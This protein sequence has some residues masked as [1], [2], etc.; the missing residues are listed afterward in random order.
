MAPAS[1]PRAP[2]PPLP[3]TFGRRATL[4]DLGLLTVFWLLYFWPILV[5]RSALI[6]YDLL[7]QHY[8][9]QAFVHRALASGQTPLWTPNILSGYPIAADPLTQLFYPPNLLMHLLSPGAFLPY[10]ALE[11]QA[12][13]HFLFAAFGTYFLARALAGSRTG[14]LLAALVFAFGSFFAW[15]LPHLSPISTLSWLPWILLAYRRA[16]LER[17]PR[18][19]AAAGFL[20]GLMALAG[21]A[22]TIVQI[23]YLLLA[24]TALA[25]WRAGRGG[26]REGVLIALLGLTPLVLGAGLAAVQ[27]LPSLALSDVTERAGLAYQEASSASFMPH[28]ALTF[29]VPNFFSFDGPGKYWASGD[30]A[31]TNGYVGLL[32]LLLAGL[33]IARAAPGRRRLTGLIACGTGVALLLAFGSQTWLYRLAFELLPAVDRVRR[34]VDFIALAQLGI[35]LL[36]AFGLAELERDRDGAVLQTLECWLGR[37]LIAAA[38]AIILG[39]LLLVNAAAEA[40]ADLTALENG[41][42]LAGVLLLAAYLAAH[43]ARSWSISRQVLLTGLLVVAAFDLGSATAGKVYAGFQRSPGSY[44]GVDWAG[45]PADATVRT[46]QAASSVAPARLY[47]TGVGSI[48]ENGPLVWGLDSIDGY[49]VLWPTYYQDTFELA[50]NA[51]GSRLFALF[52]VRYVLAPDRP[53][54]ALSALSPDSVR[55]LRDQPP[56]LYELADQGPRVWV[57]SGA[58]RLAG[59]DELGYLAAHDDELD[60]IITVSTK[61][62]EGST[63]PNTSAPPGTAEITRYADDRVTIEA[64]M[65]APG[66]VVLDDTYFPGWQARI[67]GSP[68]RVLRADHTF[69]AVWVPAGE[70][71]IDMRF[72]LPGLRAGVLVSLVSLVLLL[73]LAAYPS[74]RGRGRLVS[75]S[76]SRHAEDGGRAFGGEREESLYSQSQL[77]GPA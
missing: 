8:M 52:D 65:S 4:I 17:S 55:T 28:F 63:E 58:V 21:H 72:S 37:A 32:P 27:L 35:A 68:A 6:P 69:R 59:R 76:R 39:A 71:Q 49:S 18:W 33:G 54:R 5:T 47:P 77:S 40:H 42:I 53:P 2:A 34:P 30:L 44:I 41:L 29:I 56:Y 60:R 66:F 25:A 64:R 7:D 48:W 3:R 57:A 46:I 51:P 62:P 24:I 22:L 12:T 20:V 14:A 23:G 61:V 10:L 36:A 75:L 26:R 70:H 38:G 31:E 45:D 19:A 15:H 73:A 13:L 16:F 43:G 74:W 11:W 67:D 1:A 50:T 9:F